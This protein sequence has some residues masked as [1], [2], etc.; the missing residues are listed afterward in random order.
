MKF[1]WWVLIISIIN[2]ACFELCIDKVNNQLRVFSMKHFWSEC[3]SKLKYRNQ[4]NVNS[5]RRDLNYTDGSKF[6]RCYQR[7]YTE[8]CT[9]INQFF[10][11]IMKLKFIHGCL[12]RCK[13]WIIFVRL[14]CAQ[15][16]QQ[17]A[18]NFQLM[19]LK[20]LNYTLL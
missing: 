7:N 13:Y 18:I 5:L 6:D 12:W 10:K 1:L 17:V 9:Y 11:A 3:A 15:S 2:L 8:N 4:S 19:F 16:I 14:G 20:C